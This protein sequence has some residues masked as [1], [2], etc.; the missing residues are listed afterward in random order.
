MHGNYMIRKVHAYLTNVHLR[1]WMSVVAAIAIGPVFLSIGYATPGLIFGA[2]A[3][4]Y[5]LGCA[6]VVPLLTLVAGRLKFSTWQLAIVS[7]TFTVIGDNLRLGSMHRSEILRVAYVFWALGTLLSSPLP[8]YFLLRPLT[9]RRRYVFG[10]AIAAVALA[11][12][13][14]I[15]RITG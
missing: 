8:I 6:I 3:A 15:K 13:L 9:W 14:G 7:F 4:A 5:F 1:D 2:A 11:L 10:I 12:W